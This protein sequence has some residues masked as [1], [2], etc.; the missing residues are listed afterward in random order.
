MVKHHHLVSVLIPAYNER[1][2][3]P[4]TLQALWST[5]KVDEIIVVDDGSQDQT[6][7]IAEAWGAK[8]IRF[9]HNQGKGRAL[10]VGLA[11]TRG[12]SVLLVDADLQESAA[13]TIRLLEPI[14]QGEADLAIAVFPRQEAGKG[15]GLARKTAQLGIK[16]LTGT[17]VHA[18]LSGQRAAKKEVFQ[19][20]LPFSGGFGIE[21]GMYIDALRKGY[22][23]MEIPLLVSHCPP[24]RDWAGFLHRGK[25]FGQI[26]LALSTRLLQSKTR[27]TP[28]EEGK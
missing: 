22:R 27:F 24:G 23:I 10:S 13:Q 15:F 4:S 17:V 1:A 12:E 14:R 25:Q 28:Q 19:N 21:V 20:L 7:V 9:E 18:P 16:Y 3:L 11:F 8:V 6:G 2:R 5:G 26:C